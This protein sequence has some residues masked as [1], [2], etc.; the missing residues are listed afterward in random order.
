MAGA[1]KLDGK[2]F[3]VKEGGQFKITNSELKLKS[4]GNTVVDSS[5]NAVISESGGTVTLNKGTLGSAVVL[6]T[7]SSPIANHLVFADGKGIDFSSAAGSAS[8]SSSPVLDDYEE[9][10][11]TPTMSGASFTYYVHQGIYIKVGSLVTVG[12]HVSAAYTSGTGAF[13]INNLPFTIYNSS[14]RGGQG[15]LGC[16][17][18]VAFGAGYASIEAVSETTNAYLE[19]NISGGQRVDMT[20]SHISSPFEIRF[21]T[22]YRVA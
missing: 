6:G 20:H 11:W 19:Q 10:T 5:G 8:G 2:E 9:G 17:K 13:Y 15:S 7:T 12:G 22:T 1:L 18:G 4:S 21:T 3:L 14:V 16:M